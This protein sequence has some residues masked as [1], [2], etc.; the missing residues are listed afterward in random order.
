MV[1]MEFA[2]RLRIL[3][4]LFRDKSLIF[5]MLL[6]LTSRESKCK[7]VYLTSNI[8]I[9]SLFVA[10]TLTKYFKPDRYFKD[11]SLL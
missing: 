8:E 5:D 3:K 7:G 6:L 11:L 4:Y 9:S 10:F 1:V 2:L